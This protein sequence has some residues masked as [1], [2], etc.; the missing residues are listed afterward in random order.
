MQ[1]SSYV[2]SLGL[3]VCSDLLCSAS[4]GRGERDNQGKEERDRARK[5]L[6]M[7]LIFH[8][9]NSKPGK[10]VLPAGWRQ[11]GSCPLTAC[12]RHWW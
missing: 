2:L 8:H 9:P 10:M 11:S 12:W 1:L 6:P 3:E 7:G 4:A 5:K